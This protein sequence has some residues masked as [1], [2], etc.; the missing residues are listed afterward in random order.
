MSFKNFTGRKFCQYSHLKTVLVS[1]IPGQKSYHLRFS[2][3][4][5]QIIVRKLASETAKLSSKMQIAVPMS[6]S[7]CHAHI[8]LICFLSRSFSL[9]TMKINFSL[10]K[11]VYTFF[12]STTLVYSNWW[13]PLLFIKVTVSCVKFGLSQCKSK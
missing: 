12:F 10:Y 7:N 3:L 8:F 1:W 2:G 4:V 13:M 9:V 5:F 6:W 11:N